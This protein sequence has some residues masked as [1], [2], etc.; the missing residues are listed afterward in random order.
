MICAQLKC[1][2]YAILIDA[3]DVV[4]RTSGCRPSDYID[5]DGNV[6]SKTPWCI[7][8]DKALPAERYWPYDCIASSRDEMAGY[9]RY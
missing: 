9:G 7:L 4:D 8:A 2:Y 3:G 1:P 6:V 5:A